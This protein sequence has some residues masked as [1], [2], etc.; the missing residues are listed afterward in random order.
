MRGVPTSDPNLAVQ[1]CTNHHS[2]CPL[3]EQLLC[4]HQ[5]KASKVLRY[6]RVAMQDNSYANVEHRVRITIHKLRV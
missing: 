3:T 2:D 4:V 1:L 6:F 5:R